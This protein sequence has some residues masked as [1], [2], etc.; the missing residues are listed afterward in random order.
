M[1]TYPPRSRT[2]ASSLHLLSLPLLLLAS[3]SGAA[4]DRGQVRTEVSELIRHGQ[5]DEALARA[6]KLREE[7]PGD[8]E[9]AELHQKASVAWLLAEGRAASFDDRLE[10]ALELF[11]RAHRVDPRSEIVREWIE[12][13]H[14]GLAERWLNTALN[15]HAE[16][17]LE[18]AIAAYGMAL[19][20][21][22]GYPS[23][24]RGLEEALILAQYRE[25]KGEDYYGEGVLA[26]SEYWLEQ[27]RWH[28]TSTGKY[29][30]EYERAERRRGET[31]EMLSE[32]RTVL[33]QSLEDA[34]L[35]AGALRDY[36]LA[37]ELDPENAEA[38][39]GRARVAPEAEA[40]RILNDAGML[41]LR[42]RYDD[43][44]AQLDHA[45]MLTTRQ[46]DQIE[47]LR[48]QVA[49]QRLETMYR[50]ALNLEKDQRYPDAITAY[51]DLLDFAGY[52]KDAQT[53]RSTLEE[54][55]RLAEG[56]YAAAAK[57]TD[58]AKRLEFLRAIRGFWIEYLDVAEQIEELE[59]ALP[60]E[61]EESE[62]GEPIGA[63]APEP[64]DGAR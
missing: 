15:L 33:A 45:A 7:Q 41:V 31:E 42:E 51:G 37:F 3:C 19:E 57:E 34:G 12:K 55:V 25:G 56:Y 24:V 18:G 14:E 2:L 54:Y 1:S 40:A 38:E 13:T 46:Q 44:L 58:P 10:D 20:H 49:D 16:D 59:A 63:L 23:A 53:R 9:V 52:Y 47:A 28:F 60:P 50:L 6:E 21:V 36:E 27:A 35:F 48:L 29:L 4:R 43:A 26:L 5:F 17:D 32:Q 39:E 61:P 11:E 30:P 8:P 62:D 64:S 22:P